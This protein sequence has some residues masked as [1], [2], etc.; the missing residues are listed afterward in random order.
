MAV[1]IS[2]GIALNIT[3]GISVSIPNKL[4]NIA[5][6]ALA[7]AE[8]IEKV[9]TQLNAINAAGITQLATSMRTTATAASDI[10]TRSDRMGTAFTTAENATI[11]L[12]LALTDLEAY[13]ALATVEI[14]AL[15][16]AVTAYGAAARSSGASGVSSF[17][18]ATQG[19][20][21]AVTG[22]TG[23]V[24]AA[25]ADFAFLQG[26]TQN[27]TRAAA[28]FA[29]QMLG[30]GPILQGAFAV[31]GA[32][33]LV[34]VLVK[35]GEE[36][37][38]VVEA[39]Q[40][41]SDAAKQAAT[42]QAIAAAA[43]TET[44]EAKVS[45]VEGLARAWQ[46][47]ITITQGGDI[48]QM[49][50]K[51][52]QGF[53]QT[54]ASAQQQISDNQKITASINNKNEAGLKG[55]AAA[56]ANLSAVDSQI[57]DNKKANDILQ[58]NIDLNTK[59]ANA[60]GVTADAQAK[61]N[62][63][64]EESSKA[65]HE[66]SV[67]ATV[68]ANNRDAAIK[69]IAAAGVKDNVKEA[70]AQLKAIE[71]QYN[72]LKQQASDAGDRLSPQ[73]SASYYQNLQNVNPLNQPAITG[74]ISGFTQEAVKQQQAIDDLNKK[75]QDQVDDIGLY[76]DALTIKRDI[77]KDN[78]AIM[79]ASGGAQT[80]L[81]DAQ[82]LSV[83][84]I[85]QYAAQGAALKQVFND[86][87][88]PLR[89]FNAT[90]AATIDLWAS[91]DITA[92]QFDR[93]LNKADQTYRDAIDPMSAY[94]REMERQQ[95]AATQ[96]GTSLEM[97]VNSQVNALTN[98]NIEAGMSPEAA[99]AAAEANR[100]NITT[101]EQ[102]KQLQS[103][104]NAILD[105][106]TGAMQKLVAQQTAL[107]LAYGAGAVTEDV[108]K[109]KATALTAQ[110][111]KQQQVM[112]DTSFVTATKGALAE[113]AKDYTSTG[114][115]IGKI[116]DQTF[117]T[118]ADGAADSIGR[119]IVYADNLGDAL[120]DVARQAL[121]EIIS[122]LIKMA[123]QAVIVHTIGQAAQTAATASGV[124][125][126]A[127]LSTAWWPVAEAVSLASFGANAAPAN[128]GMTTTAVLGSVFSKFKDGV[129]GIDGPGTGRSDSIPAMLSRGESVMTSQ[130]T[131]MFGPELQQISKMA[132]T[133]SAVS[134]SSTGGGSPMQ[135]SIVNN[136]QGAK[137]ETQQ[138]GQ[139]QLRIMIRD[140][141]NQQAPKTIA[142]NLRNPNSLTSKSLKEST[143]TVRRRNS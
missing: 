88:G 94:S 65:Q 33:A 112:G 79:K 19:A 120:T 73:Q 85:V 118:I 100:L 90:Q 52:E 123:I 111:I 39:Y 92:D 67:E 137:V 108:Y 134:K 51:G 1:D 97:S 27:S 7:S 16:Q 117:K 53:M 61:Y 18:Q 133:G 138:V 60:I 45:I 140:E 36:I 106:T 44:I 10:A 89:Q 23:A 81:T 34:E 72:V 62:K 26:T 84:Q 37:G 83:T 136:K 42:D 14:V 40:N 91:G 68:L 129:I 22:A 6:N 28:N 32:I 103:D 135:V 130:A 131:S 113:Y 104:Y 93:T 75:L 116:Y 69:R 124:A 50:V 98:K 9:Q 132:R 70:E 21:N 110:I 55:V 122:G 142:N 64:V 96:L 13:A 5:T 47:F 78:L 8:A 139:N 74:K 54:S 121:Q 101:L 66:N 46:E 114:A 82:K 25:G 119:A 77:D 76:S 2:N 105:Q 63:Q 141:V 12:S 59:S 48:S 30:L 17:T 102:Q 38:K 15:T 49:S 127:T 11:Q 41:L 128:I 43:G 35:M 107:N 57:A 80:E 20:G 99:S 31:V 58:A 125:Q 87:N 109:S 24:R 95:K 56:K 4:A 3:D 71:A 126:A 29:V 143:K 115:S 86:W